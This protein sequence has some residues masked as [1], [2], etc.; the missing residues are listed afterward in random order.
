MNSSQ[1]PTRQGELLRRARGKLS[2]AEFA[3]VL[4]V[5]RSCVSRYERERLGAPTAVL[6]HCLGAI[7]AQLDSEFTN[8]PIEQA[9]RHTRSAVE[10]LEAAADQGQEHRGVGSLG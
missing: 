7:A 10:A 2:Q 5:D 4:K 3:R 6:N 8:N 1:F 9:L